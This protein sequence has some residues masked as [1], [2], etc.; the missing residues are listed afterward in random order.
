MSHP[1]LIRRRGAEPS[2]LQQSKGM[3]AV[4]GQLVHAM[5]V[6][7]FHQRFDKAVPT[8]EFHF[9][10]WDLFASETK[11]AGVIAPRGHAK[12]TAGTHCYGLTELLFRNRDFAYI[13]SNTED[14]AKEFLAEM[15]SECS[16]NEQLIKDFEIKAFERSNTTDWICVFQ[17][18]YKFRVMAYGSEQQIRGIKWEGKRPNLF[19]IDDFENPEQMSSPERRKKIK[20]TLTNAILPAGSD[21]ALYRFMATILHDDSV[22]NN[23]YKD[24]QLPSD[25]RTWEVLF[26]RAHAGFDDFTEVLWPEKFP[27]ARLWQIRQGFINQGNGEG[28][29]MEYLNDPAPPEIS[30]FKEEW[31]Q[32]LRPEHRERIEK[33][34]VKY[35][36]GVDFALETKTKSDYN[37]IVVAGMDEF[38]HLYVVDVRRARMDSKMMVD[39]MFEVQDRYHPELWAVEEHIISKSVG[40]WLNAAMLARSAEGKEYLNIEGFVPTKDKTS[41][42]R[43]IQAKMRAKHIFFDM[44]AGWWPTLKDELKRFD[45]ARHDDQVDALA[46]IGLLLT[47]A[48]PAPPQEEADE[49]EFFAAR[50]GPPVPYGRS[51][52][53]GY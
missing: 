21:D 35:Y 28:Y 49:E 44:E 50:G 11:C 8:P 48:L 43:S 24:S 30:Y 29:S 37:V 45:K 6:K 19:L 20:D 5:V 25:K 52:V 34:R 36:C 41:R 23:L 53:T 18:G 7:Y 15:M 12:S 38:G 40:P 2:K 14:Q 51:P 32:G 9:G 1:H 47:K 17:D 13:I 42:A 16:N 26:R 33:G 27:V 4:T 46:Y 3:V 39:E 22:A 31:F 10:V